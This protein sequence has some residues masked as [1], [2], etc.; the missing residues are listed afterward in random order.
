MGCI[1]VMLDF[2]AVCSFQLRW[3]QL[4]VFGSSITGLHC[5]GMILMWWPIACRKLGDFLLVVFWVLAV[6]S[7]TFLIV[8]MSIVMECDSCDC[9]DDF[10]S[11]SDLGILVFLA[12]TFGILDYV[13]IGVM[14]C[15][16]DRVKR[17][18]IQLDSFL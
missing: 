13:G 16:T 14:L 7:N 5:H 15:V 12:Y 4:M 17:F 8:S 3:F 11:G 18:R 1:S 9:R 6:T 10:G 2:L